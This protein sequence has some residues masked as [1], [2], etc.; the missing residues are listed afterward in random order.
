[1][2]TYAHVY[3]VCVS[4]AQIKLAPPSKTSITLQEL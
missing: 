3:A 1:M 2:L 4:E